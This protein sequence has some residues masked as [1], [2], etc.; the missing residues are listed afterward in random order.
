MA[1][2]GRDAVT[3]LAERL[4]IRAVTSIG[5]SAAGTELPGVVAAGTTLSGIVTGIAVVELSILSYLSE[6]YIYLC[7]LQEAVV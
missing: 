7:R 5:I 6:S 3:V 4:L 1:G 2:V